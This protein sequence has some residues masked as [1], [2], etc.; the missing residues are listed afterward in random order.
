ME[1]QQTVTGK[2]VVVGL[3]GGVDSSVTAALLKDQGYNVIGVYM[4]NW[5]TESPTLGDTPLD[6][7]AYRLFCPWYDD[8]LDAKRV[9]LQLGLPFCLWDF[10]E[11][12][13]TKVFDSFLAEFKKGRTPNPDIYCNSLVKFDDFLKKSLNELGADYVATGH[14]A[15]VEHGESGN[16]LAIP[17]DTKK[18]QTY[19]LYRLTQDQLAHTLFP[20]AGY[21]KDEVRELAKQYDLPTKYKK[22]SQGICFV[23]DVSLRDFLQHWLKEETGE[24]RD[25]EGRLIGYHVGVHFTTI[26]AK[27]AVDNSL[28]AQYYPELKHDIPH[29]YVAK[30]DVATNSV[31]AVPGH[32]HPALF[33]DRVLLE[34]VTGEVLL[35]GNLTARLR[36]GGAL[37]E[38]KGVKSING[39]H[40]EVVF[41]EP[42]RAITPGQHLVL[43]DTDG[44][45]VGGGIITS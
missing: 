6:P 4:K 21:T 16:T 10:R 28:I 19:F 31:I 23:G 18:D 39:T 40:V 15:R 12:Y 20:L 1:K 5:N 14:Y 7:D 37:V 32:D 22:D 36:H 24:I 11:A 17:K 42:Q 30:K 45:V 2:T 43:Y 38:I 8:Y 35:A 13:K 29:F 34:D 44:R 26:G 33:S 27:I 25:L 9:A 3:S 41:M